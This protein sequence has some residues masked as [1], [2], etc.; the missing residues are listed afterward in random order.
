M[1]EWI[2]GLGISGISIVGGRM[3]S[4]MSGLVDFCMVESMGAGLMEW[5]RAWRIRGL[6]AGA[7]NP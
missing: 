4:R 6:K 3:G 1:D 5:Y 2:G 7:S